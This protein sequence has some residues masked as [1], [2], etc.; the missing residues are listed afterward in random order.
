ME[1]L[2]THIHSRGLMTEVLAF[3]RAAA[4]S[5]TMKSRILEDLKRSGDAGLTPDEWAE[6]NGALINTVRR[7]FTDLWK[8]GQIRHHPGDLTRKNSSGNACV[9]WVLGADP[10]SAPRVAVEYGRGVIAGR[11]AVLGQIEA[12]CQTAPD[13]FFAVQRLLAYLRRNPEATG[14]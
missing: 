5:K 8:A 10:R 12:Y 3:E 1:E 4:V 11:R 14:G 2:K 7:R 13:D 6:A 9:A